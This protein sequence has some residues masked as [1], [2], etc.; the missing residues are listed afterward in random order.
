M[1]LA[2]PLLAVVHLMGGDVEQMLATS[3]AGAQLGVA[4]GNLLPTYSALA[5]QAWAESRLGQ[6]DAARQSL[7]QAEALSQNIGGH[8][9][10]D[11]WLAAIKTEMAL[12]AGQIAEALERAEDA[13]HFARSV[14]GK[15]AEAIARRVWA[16]ALVALDP[17]QWDEADADA[18][19]A[20]SWR[21]LDA[22]EAR[23]EAAR[24]RVVWGKILRERGD[25]Q[26]AREHLEKAAAQFEASGLE[27]ELEEARKLL[28]EV[29]RAD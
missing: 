4:S 9:L 27:R 20:Q 13:V 12:N 8:Y 21:L 22:G 14:D 2:Y 7:A 1:S 23:L 3:R 6:H 26:A 10:I 19:L 29:K 25:A 15:F 24:T 18:H 28:N 5:T 17:P 11:D 16:E